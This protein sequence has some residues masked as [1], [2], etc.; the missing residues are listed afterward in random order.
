MR[1]RESWEVGSK[2]GGSSTRVPLQR[3]L[4][5]C[6]LRRGPSQSLLGRVLRACVPVASWK[7]RSGGHHFK[8]DGLQ[9]WAVHRL[10]V[11]CDGL[12]CKIVSQF[13]AWTKLSDVAATSV[14]CERSVAMLMWNCVVFFQLRPHLTVYLRMCSA[15]EVVPQM[16]GAQMVST[17][18]RTCI[19]VAKLEWTW[20]KTWTAHHR[21]RT[22]NFGD[23][24]G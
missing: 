14:V 17:A 19:A 15:V 2:E 23:V 10:K 5:A 11:S 22:A 6:D 21:C 9:R 4:E 16:I 7:S 13:Q 1:T 8:C 3:R 20:S 12:T 24:I 18:W